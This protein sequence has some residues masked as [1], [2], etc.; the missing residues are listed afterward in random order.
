M[1]NNLEGLFNKLFT[2]ISSHLTGA[3]LVTCA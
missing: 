2:I 1:F 3:G